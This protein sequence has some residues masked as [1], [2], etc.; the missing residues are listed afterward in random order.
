[1]SLGDGL[2]S[3]QSARRLLFD[4]LLER[5]RDC[6]PRRWPHD[7]RSGAELGQLRAD[8]RLS[9]L[10]EVRV[11]KLTRLHFGTAFRQ[12]SWEGFVPTLRIVSERNRSSVEFYDYKRT[13][14]EFGVSRAF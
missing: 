6:L 1:M 5:Q 4:A 9:L 2:R 13:R 14:T 3:L 11:D 12:L 7:R 10:P 8:E